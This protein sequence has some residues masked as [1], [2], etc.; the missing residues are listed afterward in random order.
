MNRI[1]TERRK[2]TSDMLNFCF[3]REV[4]LDHMLVHKA[5][6]PPVPELVAKVVDDIGW[7]LRQLYVWTWACACVHVGGCVQ[8]L[9]S[10]S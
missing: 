8:H 5:A 7:A 9:M 1:V 6:Y 3:K 10:G 4:R 2:D